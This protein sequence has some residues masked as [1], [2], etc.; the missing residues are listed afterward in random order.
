MQAIRPNHGSL[1][2]YRDAG[3]KSGG[4][5]GISIAN[6]AD[7]FFCLI[8]YSEILLVYAEAANLA[9]GNPS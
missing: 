7:G 2:K 6:K 3:P 1:L 4:Y 5:A 8:R 9:E